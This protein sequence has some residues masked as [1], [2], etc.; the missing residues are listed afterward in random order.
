MPG[1]GGQTWNRACYLN[2]SE[3]NPRL[4]LGDHRQATVAPP[5]SRGA[6]VLVLDL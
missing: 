1:T 5:V 4:S 2:L 3:R 6:L